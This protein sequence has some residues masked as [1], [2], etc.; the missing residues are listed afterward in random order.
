MDAH[1]KRQYLAFAADMGMSAEQAER[2][3]VRY[4][5]RAGIL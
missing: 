4:R 1:R 5:K 2:A 3:G